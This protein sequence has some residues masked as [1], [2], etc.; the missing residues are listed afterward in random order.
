MRITVN[1]DDDILDAAQVMAQGRGVSL[2]TVISQL[3]RR[4]LTS[5]HTTPERNGIR[6][7]PVRPKAGLVTPGVVRTLLGETE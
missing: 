4:G 3:V 5:S 6:L 2:G 7:F 1:L